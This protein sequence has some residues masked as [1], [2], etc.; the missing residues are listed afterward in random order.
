MMR[1]QAGVE[2]WKVARHAD[3]AVLLTIA[4]LA[5]AVGSMLSVTVPVALLGMPTR[6]RSKPA[7]PVVQ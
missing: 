4:V 2:Y 6:H 1:Q 5:A 7:G 3:F